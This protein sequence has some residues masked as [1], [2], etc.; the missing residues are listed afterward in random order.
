MIFLSVPAWTSIWEDIY[1]EDNFSHLFRSSRCSVQKL[2][3]HLKDFMKACGGHQCNVCSMYIH[4]E[5]H[6]SLQCWQG[7]PKNSVWLHKEGKHPCSYSSAKK[8]I[9]EIRWKIWRRKRNT[10]K[11]SSKNSEI[12]RQMW[13]KFMAEL[14][15]KPAWSCCT[16]CKKRKKEEKSTQWRIL[17]RAVARVWGVFWLCSNATVKTVSMEPNLQFQTTTN[18]SKIDGLY[19]KMKSV[20]GSNMKWFQL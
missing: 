2:T 1:R 15:R 5:K 13:V 7:G 3:P 8:G 9:R 6:K 14:C 18:Q 10:T 17:G 20:G 19:N 11:I 4:I 12:F 16:K